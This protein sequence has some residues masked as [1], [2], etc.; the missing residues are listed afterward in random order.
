MDNFQRKFIEEATDLILRLEQVLLSLDKNNS[1]KTLVDEVFR[2]MHSL[3]GGSGMF[4]FQLISDYTHQLESVY[5]LVRND[6]MPLTPEILEITFASVDH[7]RNIINNQGNKT[8][9]IT[10][11]QNLLLAKLSQIFTQ[12][13][14]P[15]NVTVRDNEIV[16][17]SKL[18]NYYI[19]FNP[20]STVLKTGNNPLYI[21]DE[22]VNLAK[23]LV[24]TRLIKIPL[25]NNLQ[26]DNCYTYWEIFLESNFSVAQ[27]KDIFMF[28]ED[29]AEIIIHTL[30]AENFIENPEFIN[31]CNNQ[32]HQNKF[33]IGLIENYLQQY[34]NVNTNPDTGKKTNKVTEKLKK[35]KQENVITSIRVA[36]DKIDLLMNLVSE[37]ITSQAGLNLYMEQ[38][39]LIGLKPIAESIENIARQL[40]DTAFHIS[41]I[42][43][44]NLLVRFQ[45]LIRDLSK[46][47]GKEIQFIS[48]GAD[49]ELDKTLIEA[50]TEPLMHILRNSVDHGIELSSER[51]SA[52]KQPIGT[53]LLKSYYSGNQI[54]IKISDD[55]KG[56]SPKFIK[57]K[58][59]QKGFIKEDAQL[60][61]KEIIELIF[62]PGFTTTSSVTNVSGR[63]VGMDVVKRKIADVRGT[64]ELH[65]EKNKGTEITIKLPLTLSII[66]G[67]LLKLSDIDLIIPLSVIYTIYPVK[68]S[69]L[70]KS[71]NNIITING[72]Q[73]PFY[74]LRTEF[75]IMD[76]IPEQMEMIIV[77]YETAFVGIAVDYIVGE[78]QAVVK[79]LGK[80]FR[81]QDIFSGAT[82]LGDGTVAL[83][84]DFM[85]II[86]QISNQNKNI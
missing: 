86:A 84:V 29:D 45:R 74:N 3:K 80:M 12:K 68:T 65:S 67:M 34:E 50:I 62:L 56:I 30:H 70:D 15:T 6:K 8:E 37:L 46:E 49:T 11:V 24:F 36:S 39:K 25:L 9:S 72:L 81:K 23:S 38:N 60:T 58:A 63:G 4:G 1:N 31:F 47:F 85:K 77:K 28:V 40:R 76:N 33:E 18:N 43:I 13:N 82:I 42:P 21:I 59:I 53:I 10:T 52:G 79:P 71:F 78:Y 14:E 19:Y 64:V 35:F 44:D 32:K 55:G 16:D 73:Y 57:E 17:N 75:N 2:I 41:L 66:D 22:L 83:V 26:H 7:I 54:V 20:F 69:K 51:I 48:E 61:D 5:D 27:V